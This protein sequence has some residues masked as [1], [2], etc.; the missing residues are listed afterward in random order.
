MPI[1]F[2]FTCL[3]GLM[4]EL[5][6]LGSGDKDVIGSES[7]RKEFDAILPEFKEQL[8]VEFN[9]LYGKLGVDLDKSIDLE[10]FES[11]YLNHGLDSQ[12][13]DFVRKVSGCNKDQVE[14]LGFLGVLGRLF[15]MCQ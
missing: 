6:P 7:K 11:V 5:R 10:K 9:C 2:L 15:E 3:C 12:I 1:S 4:S 13:K 14:P 8:L